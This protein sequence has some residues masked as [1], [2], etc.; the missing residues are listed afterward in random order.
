MEL[1]RSNMTESAELEYGAQSRIWMLFLFLHYQV[2]LAELFTSLSQLH[3]LKNG[4]KDVF[5]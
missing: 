2:A 1:S 3:R 4:S 5:L